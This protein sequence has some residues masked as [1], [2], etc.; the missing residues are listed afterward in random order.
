MNRENEPSLKVKHTRVECK[1]EGDMERFRG[2]AANISQYSTLV[3]DNMFLR[4]LSA[5]SPFKGVACD[6]YYNLRMFPLSPS[7]SHCWHKGVLA[8]TGVDPCYGKLIVRDTEAVVR[9]EASSNA[10]PFSQSSHKTTMLRANA[11]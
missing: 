10:H 6:S 1:F 4:L 5:N 3:W 7:S 11:F 2:G 8:K 9:A